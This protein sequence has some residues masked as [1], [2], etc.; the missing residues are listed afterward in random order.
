[1]NSRFLATVWIA[2]LSGCSTTVQAPEE[3]AG[4]ASSPVHL[5]IA[6]SPHD[7]AFYSHSGLIESRYRNA[8]CGYTILA[9]HSARQFPRPEWAISVYEVID[10]DAPAVR[11][12]AAAFRVTSRDRQ[13][14]VE[15]R[16]PIT[17]LTFTLKGTGTTLVANIVQSNGPSG[18]INAMLQTAPA[19]VLMKA[20]YYGY[21][22][23]ISLT[24][25][26]DTTDLLEVRNWSS[27][28][29]D[30]KLGYFQ[31]C[32]YDLYPVQAGARY[33][34][35]EL[36]YGPAGG[37]QSLHSDVSYCFG[38]YDVAGSCPADGRDRQ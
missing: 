27:P 29:V 38:P 12:E 18:G 4:Q 28:S 13:A 14:P 16:A 22:V 31:Q 11:V 25:Q 23:E 35:Y 24:H 19:Q 20:L 30:W 32:M 6:V 21:P 26:D 9:N 8:T 36:V 2:T 33:F 1:M 7:L 15:A 10:K 37:V 17:A 3:S 5:V 34:L